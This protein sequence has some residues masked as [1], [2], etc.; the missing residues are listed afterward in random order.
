MKLFF[1][2]KQKLEKGVETAGQTSQKMLEISRLTLRIR[3]KKEDIDRLVEQLGRKMV[4][5]WK[6][7]QKWEM[8]ESI[9]QTLQQIYDINKEIEELQ[10]EL[11]KIKNNL[12]T[13]KE[14]AETVNLQK[15]ENHFIE[16][17]T[18]KEVE[19]DK[20]GEPLEATAIP[21]IVYLCPFCAHQVEPNASQCTHCQKPF[22]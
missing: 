5:T 17:Q 1:D 14:E 11:E 18:K 4:E 7:D 2:L 13:H 22:Y 10:A 8:T 16:G 3:G 19:L 9:E 15:E 6:P 21:T 12:I 20:T